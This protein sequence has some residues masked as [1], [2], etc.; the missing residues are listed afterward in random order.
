MTVNMTPEEWL[1][2][3][4]L[5]AASLDLGK[6]QGTIASPQGG[7]YRI[8]NKIGST[9]RTALYQCVMADGRYGVLKIVLDALDNIG[10]DREAM[11]LK[12]LRERALEIEKSNDGERPFNLHYFFPELVESFQCA[13]QGGRRINILAFAPLVDN[14]GNLVP[15]IAITER[16]K[17]RVDPM[18]SV[19]ILGK[20][21]KT[22]GF[23]HDQ[24]IMNNLITGGNVLL[25]TS[26]HGII[27]F[28][29]TSTKHY[30]DSVVPAKYRSQEIAQAAQ[31]AIVALGGDP[32]TGILPADPRLTNSWYQDF[33]WRLA[34]GEFTDANQAHNQ[35][36]E[37]VFEFWPRK[38]HPFT[39]IPLERR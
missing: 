1:D 27:V 7:V 26:D 16:D 9:N 14:I 37:L 34:K 22:I 12:M 5:G 20:L 24:G 17:V 13:S 21:L 6:V 18:T 8:M 23:A 3:I 31:I 19:W 15:L 35:F 38:F 32:K 28:D 2:G 11:T 25:E 39:T 36:Y 33:V 30:P 29:W 4:V 10:L